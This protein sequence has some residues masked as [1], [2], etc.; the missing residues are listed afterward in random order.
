MHD[1]PGGRDGPAGP[2]AGH[3][4]RGINAAGPIRIHKELVATQR[5]VAIQD[6]RSALGR[7]RVLVQVHRQR[8]D[9]RDAE[10][11]RG[12][13][14]SQFAHKGQH[15]TA[16]A[17]VGVKQDAV[18]LRHLGQIGDGVHHAM[19]IGRGR[20]DDQDCVGRHGRF[21]RRHVRRE[22]GLDRRAHR[23]DREIVRRFFKGRVGRQ[24]HDHLGVRDLGPGG[25]RP[26]AGRLDRHQDALRPARGHIAHHLPVPTQQVGGHG[27]HLGLESPQAGKGGGV[28]AVLIEKGRI[29]ALEKLRYLFAEVVNQAPGLPLAPLDVT[30]P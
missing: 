8:R 30:L 19:R 9:A 13:R 23:L 26:I 2:G 29:G 12:D 21:D 7:V 4:G 1:R 20:A 6:H 17:G 10:I 16:D 18:L 27:D 11:E 22:I 14:V 5:R 24:G 28:E 25:A 3:G 15:K